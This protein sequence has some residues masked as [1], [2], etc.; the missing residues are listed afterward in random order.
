MTT[1][2]REALAND[3]DF[4]VK[5]KQASLKAANDLLA[6]IDQP[7]YVIQYAQTI[8]TDPNSGNWLTS[9]TYG[10][11]T[12]PAITE[13]STDDDIQFTV[14]SIFTKYAKAYYRIVE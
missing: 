8:I 10:V 1:T 14:N 2:E 9:M 12:N 5:V 4:K 7:T 11:L 3:P 13:G 6:A